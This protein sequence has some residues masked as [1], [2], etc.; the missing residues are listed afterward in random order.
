MS[1]DRLSPA[2]SASLSSAPVR[3][4]FQ[5]IDESNWGPNWIMDPYFVNWP[6]GDDEPPAHYGALVGAGLAIDRDTVDFQSNG[7]ACNLTVDSADGYL[8]Q[9]IFASGD[10]P[11][12]YQGKDFSF[13][14]AVKTATANL[15]K[16]GIYDGVDVS[17][18]T[19]LHTGGDSWEWLVGT[20]TLDGSADEL[21]VRFQVD[22][23]GAPGNATFDLPVLIPG[24]IPPK[25]FIPCPVSEGVLY[26]P[27]VGSVAVDTNK[28]RY[29]GGRPFLVR[30]V[31]LHLDT[32]NTDAALIVDVNHWDGSAMQ[33]M[34]STKPQI[35]DAAATKAGGANPDGTHRYRCFGSHKDDES[36]TDTLLSVDID[37]IGS[38]IAGADLEIL[39]RAIQFQRPW[40]ALAA[41]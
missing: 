38:T 30:N 20:R 12:Y 19:A 32:V 17:Y 13:A 37:Q 33:S 36:E 2:A 18:T 27:I 26:Y 3:A 25:R 39:I 10:L 24:L 22:L 28:F 7:M 23:A 4:N 8:P 1:W 21:E 34:F 31:T 14:V 15:A 5:G 35:A 29:L 40:G 16:M 6:E 11:A 41:F 9:T